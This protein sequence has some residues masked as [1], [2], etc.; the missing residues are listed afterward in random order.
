MADPRITYEPRP[1]ATPEGEVR[2]LAAAYS[3]ILDC[4]AK[5]KGGARHTAPNDAEGRSGDGFHAD[6]P[7]LP[8]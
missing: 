6:E 7:S 5:K 8:S 4:C 1:G 2:D 3:F